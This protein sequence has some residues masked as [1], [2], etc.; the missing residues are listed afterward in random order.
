MPEWRY[1]GFLVTTSSGFSGASGYRDHFTRESYSIGDPKIL[2]GWNADNRPGQGPDCAGIV[3]VRLEI[4]PHCAARA[5]FLIG[6]ACDENE[7]DALRSRLS[8]A[9]VDAALAIKTEEEGRR[10]SSFSV[11]TG[12]SD[13]DA[14]INSFAKQQMV[15][16]LINKSGFRD[17]LQNDMGVAMFDWPMARQNLCRA[18]SSQHFGGSIPHSFRPWNRHQYSD[19]PVLGFCNAC[20]ASKK[21]GTWPFW[22]SDF[23]FAT[24]RGKK[25]FRQDTLRAMRFLVK[26]LESTVSATSTLRT[27]MMGS[28]HRRKPGIAKA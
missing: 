21:A 19:M 20:R 27:G 26:T 10:A 9:A 18:I 24:S 2:N 4:A 8:P 23:L 28:N 11:D 15:S 7:V 5:D 22:T 6:R 14:L 25:P 1:N 3:Q 17:N 16:Y 12:N 13:R